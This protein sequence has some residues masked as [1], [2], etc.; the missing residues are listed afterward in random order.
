MHF[1]ED[2]GQEEMSSLLDDVVDTCP[3]PMDQ[4][5][6]SQL[7]EVAEGLVSGWGGLD[8]KSYAVRL[9]ILCGIFLHGHRVPDRE[10]DV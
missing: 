6:S 2:V 3:V 5:P 4:R 10:R 7:K 1:G 8:G 9:T